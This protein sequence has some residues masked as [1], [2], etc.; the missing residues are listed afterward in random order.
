VPSEN[1]ATPDRRTRK[2]DQ[3]RDNLL[4]L[5]ADLVEERGLPGLT[6]AALAEVGDYA[7]AS[8]YTYFA[9]R[10][11]L[12]SALQARALEVLGALGATS[13]AEWDRALGSPTDASGRRVAALARLCAF[14]DLFLAAPMTHSRE[15]R[16]QQELLATPE[17]DDGTASDAV[18]AA[19]MAV[20]ELPRRLLEA[21]VDAK[22]LA[23]PAPVHNHAGDPVDGSMARTLTWIAALN[24]VLLLD[25]LG[26]A[27]AVPGPTLGRDLT[28]SILR[29]WG[30]D[31]TALDAACARADD[32]SSR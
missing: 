15:F 16:L 24:G 11:A 8:L 28:L 19:A 13:L 3:R 29:G 20:L 27:V 14:S 23:E 25:R 17:S 32:W 26:A 9:S 12:V 10:S 1:V 30:A 22:A 21:A 7:P 2:R 5:A 18:I 6:M 4:D 31:V